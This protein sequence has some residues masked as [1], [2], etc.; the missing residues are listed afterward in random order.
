M[1]NQVGTKKSKSGSE[2][3]VNMFAPSLAHSNFHLP[4][5]S[6]P[7]VLLSRTQ[8]LACN[9]SSEEEE[10]EAWRGEERKGV[11]ETLPSSELI[12]CGG[13]GEGHGSYSSALAVV[14]NRRKGGRGRRKRRWRALTDGK[15]WRKRGEGGK[16]KEGEE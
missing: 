16:K 9:P 4:L 3:N 11:K 12:N 6:F 15:R 2:K 8:K 1:R 10:E 13:G 14:H 7:L 5:F